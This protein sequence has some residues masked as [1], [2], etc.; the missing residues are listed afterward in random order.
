MDQTYALKHEIGDVVKERYAIR[1]VLGAGAFGTVYRVEEAIGARTVTLACK[2]MHVLNE[3]NSSSDERAAALAMFQEEAYLLQT[4]RHPNIPTAHFEQQKG[5]WLACPMCGHTF[6]GARTCPNHGAVLEVVRE[7]YYLIMDFIEGYDLEEKL[8]ENGRPLEEE[9]VLDWTLQV[10]DALHRVH[11]EGLSHRDIK[12]ANIK[13]QASSGRAMLIDFGLVKPSTVVGGYG[14][15]LKRSSTRMGTLG[16]APES[17]FE[18]QNPDARTDIL[19]LGMTLY[20]LLSFRDPT[21]ENDLAAMRRTTPDALNLKLSKATNDLIL[22]AIKTN[23]DERYPNIEEFRRDVQA[24]RYP[25]AVVCPHCGQAQRSAARPTSDSMCERCGRTLLDAGSKPKKAAVVANSKT[26]ASNNPYEPRIREIQAMLGNQ[27]EPFQFAGDARLKEIDAQLAAIGKA[28]VGQGNKCPSCRKNDLRAVTGQAFNGCMICQGGPLSRRVTEENKCAVCRDGNLR[29]RTLGEHEMRCAVCRKVELKEE[30]RS[31]FVGM[32]VDY[33]GV[34]PH[35]RAQ[36]DFLSGGDAR[37]D[38][39]ETDPFGVA[40]KHGGQ[41]LPIAQWRTLAGSTAQAAQCDKCAAQWDIDESGQLTLVDTSSD[42]FGVGALMMGKS[43]SRL[44]WAKIAATV[45]VEQ[46]N[47]QCQKCQAEFDYLRDAKIITLL[48]TGNVVPTWSAAL[49]GKAMPLPAFGFAA[50]GK[51][52]GHAGMMCPNCASE[53]DDAPGGLRLVRATSGELQ[54]RNGETH[55]LNDWQRIGQGLPSGQEAAAFN[56]ERQQLLQRKQAEQQQWQARLRGQTDA[57]NREFNELLRQSVIGGHIPIERVSQNAPQNGPQ[58]GVHIAVRGAQRRV[59]L[60]ASENVLWE[61]PAQYCSLRNEFGTLLWTR[62]SMGSF[63]ITSERIMFSVPGDTQ[64]LWQKPLRS[65]ASAE[66]Q[67]VQNTPVVLLTFND[68][69]PAAGFL[70]DQVKWD[71]VV[72][73]NVHS[74]VFAPHE[75][76][77]LLMQQIH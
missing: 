60:R 62:H 1:A 46:G 68:Q 12:P 56:S 48:K 63:L 75:V 53:W 38:S 69:D 6:K 35:C 3:P 5:I 71:V 74:L 14:T 47:L 16:Y 19:A 64:Q 61:S 30:K 51:T 24:A 34:C 70:L 21:D 33:W 18:Q 28:S 8:V 55:Y 27:N 50:A 40:A 23:P 67:Y 41:T 45:P 42:P 15:V 22:R 20:R 39:W 49:I 76:A 65:V 59:Q 52:S 36:F 7:R 17:P 58:T 13:I 25:V 11:S 10:C 32:V 57:L 66:M 2:E 77:S 31:R 44:D 9:T 73:G 54:K 72:D 37:L 29:D 4:L 26:V 43:L